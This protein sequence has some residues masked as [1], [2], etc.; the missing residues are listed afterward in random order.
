MDLGIAGRTALVCAS[1]AGL[2][3][4]TGEA[5]AAEGV[6][7]VFSGR[8][9]DLAAEIAATYDG[10]VG[11]A[12]DLTS[13]QGGRALVAAAT[14]AVG[15][16]DM[17][18]LNGPGPRPGP[19]TD[20]DADGLDAAFAS[21]VETHVAIVAAVLPGMRE[22]RWGRILG[23]GSSGVASP[24]P[25]LALSN[26][27]R[28][29]FAAYMKSLA[30][31]VAPDG[32]TV[33]LVLPGRIATDRVAALDQRRA[34]SSG[35]TVDDVRAESEAS[36]PAARYGRAQEFGSVAAFL[37]SESAG[38]VTGVAVRCDGGLVGVL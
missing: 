5:L 38:Y 6:R 20:V 4:A 2:G 15:P 31:E 35:R 10:C 12:A 16:L 9:Q 8:R 34:D 30:T 17:I 7:V 1:T 29:A 28:A 14:D 27:G 24:I 3:R 21:L 25:D 18:V 11:L 13:P 33:N 36:I 22:R 37:C 23:I 19:A 26:I 32:V